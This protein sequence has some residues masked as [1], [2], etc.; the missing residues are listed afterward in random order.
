MRVLVAERDPEAMLVLKRSLTEWGYDV[1]EA[2]N[3]V[4]ADRLL[5]QA[6]GPRLAVL[7]A[8]LREMSGLDVC[9]RVR[10]S[11]QAQY[12]YII[13]LTVPD[14]GQAASAVFDAGA[15][16]HLLKPIKIPD[17]RLRLKAAGRILRL[18]AELTHIYEIA[19]TVMFLVDEQYRIRKLNRAG[20]SVLL[21]D[22]RA[23]GLSPYVHAV[24]CVQSLA[25]D[26]G[27]GSHSVC[28]ECGLRRTIRQ[29]V[30]DGVPHY[31]KEAS[32]EAVGD[33]GE[34]EFS[35]LVTATPV[36]TMGEKLVF[37]CVED[38]TDLKR[39]ESRLRQSVAELEAFNELAVGREL[40]MIELKRQVNELSGQLGLPT[41]YDV[42][43]APE[44]LARLQAAVSEPCSSAEGAHD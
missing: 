31:R 12:V 32:I 13:L 27:C 22:E 42:G 17:L 26:Q 20:T 10:E 5:R 38:V 16:D 4:E 28:R 39:S 15:D 3:G 18:Q 1:L 43:F 30:A 44:D 29:L 40:R 37:I 24:R 33:A 6:D 19:P 23:P 11:R 35:F 21:E 14:Y 36:L 7:D 34:Q 25:K 8:S 41:P 9:R 2:R